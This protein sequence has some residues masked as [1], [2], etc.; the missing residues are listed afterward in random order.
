MGT[1]IFSRAC[2]LATVL[3]LAACGGGGGGGGDNNVGTSAGAGGN[4]TSAPAADPVASS[5]ASG[6]V[7][8][9]VAT[10]DLVPNAA[11]GRLDYAAITA[12]PV[13]GAA[14]ELIGIDGAVLASG[15]TT[16]TGNYS[17]SVPV[18]TQLQLRVRTQM[19]RSDAVRWDF[20]VRD[21]TAS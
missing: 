20:S 18:N 8:H 7:V 15:T 9:G 16:D 3:A 14:V 11:N 21:N 6:V 17:L 12:K 13:R 1:V 19:V 5:A 2:M 10:F 4:T